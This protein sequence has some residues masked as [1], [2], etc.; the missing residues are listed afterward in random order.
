[1]IDIKSQI[2]N[3]ALELED[4]RVVASAE[5]WELADIQSLGFFVKRNFKYQ[6]AI[7]IT[8]QSGKNLTYHQV[9]A[10]LNSTNF[11]F[12][13]AQTNGE[14][15]RFTDASGNLLS[16]WIKDWDAVSESA[17][18]WVK[19]SSIPANSSVEIYMYYGN[20]S[21]SSE[22]N[23]NATF[24]FF[25]DFECEFG[26]ERYENN[27]VIPYYT[28]EGYDKESST[29]GGYCIYANGKYWLYF[30]YHKTE[31]DPRKI[32]LGKS[33]D[34]YNFTVNA[35]ESPILEAGGQS[36]E[37]TCVDYPAVL[38]HNSEFWLYY[39]SNNRIGLAKSTDGENF[40]RI[41]NGIDG[42]S[43]V[44]EPGA[45]G[46][47]D[48]EFVQPMAIIYRDDLNEFWLYYRGSKS[49]VSGDLKIGLATSTDGVNFTKYSGNPIF[50][51]SQSWEGTIVSELRPFYYDGKWRAYYR[52]NG[53]F[54]SK[55]GY[56]E[57]DDGKNW[58]KYSENPI[59]GPGSEDWESS[60]VLDP[61]FCFIGGD[62]S[63]KGLLYYT[64]KKETGTYAHNQ[65]GVATQK[66]KGVFYPA[67]LEKWTVESGSPVKED[68]VLKLSKSEYVS[69]PLSITEAVWEVRARLTGTGVHEIVVFDFIADENGANGYR[70]WA[71]SDPN[72][73]KT[74][75]KTIGGTVII[76]SN[77]IPDSNYHWYKI[78]RDGNGNFKLFID[79]ELQGTGQDNTYNTSQKFW[80]RCF[81]GDQTD[82]EVWYD[83]VRVRKYADPEPSV[84][85]G[86]ENTV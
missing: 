72:G 26:L 80:L 35:Y 73:D 45:S 22:S 46:E 48:D 68:D 49:G 53:G 23:G 15:I 55:I 71:N 9:L 16:Y 6:R 69:T 44:L 82:Y 70:L 7:T 34:G 30:Y 27:P 8:E 18:V 3:P 47:W 28:P 61:T 4:I 43:K 21:A 59:F 2:I 76:Q 62:P 33:T 10:G 63:N 17:K 38:Y 67:P 40:T 31:A 19:V 77:F 25:D 14:D 13:H 42:T 83:E 81:W 39:T 36:W 29:R 51:P 60:Y 58:T 11:D 84:S 78:T 5:G 74:Q 20:P 1:M 65:I 66:T 79:G 50:E 12:S 52:G 75:L 41:T 57:S 85:I 56:A 32:G 86:S 37:G 54:N 64:G 24:L